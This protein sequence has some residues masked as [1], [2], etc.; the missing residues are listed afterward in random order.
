[1]YTYYN[2][3]KPAFLILFDKEY[4]LFSEKYLRLAI[5]TSV[6]LTALQGILGVD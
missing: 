5:Q 4:F 3:F 1:M 2:S 6:P